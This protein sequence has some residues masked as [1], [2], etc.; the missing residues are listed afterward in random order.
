[1]RFAKC[2]R[3]RQA[4]QGAADAARALEPRE[5]PG[6][7]DHLQP[8]PG[9][10]A[11]GRTGGPVAGHRAARPGD[12]PQRHHQHQKQEREHQDAQVLAPVQPQDST[13]EQEDERPARKKELGA[14][15]PNDD[16]GQGGDNQPQAQTRRP[17]S[18][19]CQPVPPRRSSSTPVSSEP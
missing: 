14:E 6:A 4:M 1:M 11:G 19:V 5:V 10:G 9:N 18:R 3:P 17:G 12:E 2:A 16:K 15:L 8:R 13:G 7:G